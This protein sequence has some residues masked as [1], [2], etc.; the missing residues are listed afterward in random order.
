LPHLADL[1]LLVGL[2]VAGE[3][4]D[5]RLRRLVAWLARCRIM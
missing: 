5:G 1:D 3:G 4:V 2:D